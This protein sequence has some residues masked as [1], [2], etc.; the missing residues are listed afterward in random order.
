MPDIPTVAESGVP[1][2]EASN[3]FGLLVPAG[4][5]ADIVNRLNAEAGKAMQSADVKE[6]LGGLGF[7]VQASTPPEFAAFLKKEGDKWAKVVKASG[8]KAE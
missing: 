6:K 3:W 8:A 7:E 5:P 4:T 2:F 1:G